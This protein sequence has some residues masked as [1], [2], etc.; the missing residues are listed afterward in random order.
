M[1]RLIKILLICLCFVWGTIILNSQ[2]LAITMSFSPS[3]AIIGIGDPLDVDIIIS[4]MEND[5]LAEFSFDVN[6]DSAVLNFDSYV[7]GTELTDP[8]FGQ[9]DWSAGDLGGGAI[10]LSELS[11]LFDFSAQPDSFTLAT[12]SFIGNAIG[13]S[14]LSFTNVI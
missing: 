13:N 5:D 11:G 1:N 12:V 4:G 14:G 10:N 7:L 3:S 8:V 9:D 2:A 6:Y